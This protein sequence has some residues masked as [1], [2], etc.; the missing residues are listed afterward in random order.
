MSKDVDADETIDA[1]AVPS[2]EMGGDPACWLHLFCPDCGV[3]LDGAAHRPDCQD[4]G[5]SDQRP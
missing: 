4:Q 5:Q 1:Q 3:Q 2:E